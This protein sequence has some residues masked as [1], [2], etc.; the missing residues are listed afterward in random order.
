MASSNIHRKGL[1]GSKSS[2]WLYDSES[3]FDLT[4]PSSPT[5]PPISPR[6]TIH[7]RTSPITIDP[8][9]S[10]LVIVDMQNFFLSPQLG[11]PKDSKGLKAQEQLLKYAIPAA[12]KAGIRVIWLNWGLTQ[13]EVDEMPPA[14]LRLF[15][16]ETVAKD[17]PGYEDVESRQAAIDAHIVNQ[18]TEE[19]AKRQNIEAPARDARIYKGLGSEVGRVKLEDGSEVQGGKLLMRGQW[20]SDLTPE[21]KVV[22]E[23]GLEANPPDVWIHKNRMSG[24]W[25]DKTLCTEFL[26]KEGIRTL[27]FTGVNT[28]QCVGGSL[29]DAFTKGWDCVLL[30]DGAGTTSPAHSQDRIT[31]NGSHTWGVC[32]TCVDF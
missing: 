29:Q 26:E 31:F 8:A 14:T 6:V 32:S 5:A 9:K 19:L 11:R 25:G 20:N 7:T 17:S 13:R 23:E 16:F 21:L 1:I 3:G 15:G 28:D 2:F 4:H 30:S 24:L 10:A 22:Y 27:F 18:G 12:R